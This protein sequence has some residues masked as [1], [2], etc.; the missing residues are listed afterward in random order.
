MSVAACGFIQQATD[1]WPAVSCSQ[2]L[3][4][5]L[6]LSLSLSLWRMMSLLEWVHSIYFEILN[7]LHISRSFTTCAFF[8]D[9]L[10]LFPL[11]LALSRCLSLSLDLCLSLTVFCVQTHCFVVADAHSRS[12]TRTCS[13]AFA[14]L[15][16]ATQSFATQPLATHA[17]ATPSCTDTWPQTF[18]F[19]SRFLCLSFSF[20]F[21]IFTLARI[22][23]CSFPNDYCICDR[24]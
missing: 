1:S 6:S 16:L 17:L 10:L 21:S 18:L 4:L 22:R 3:L 24:S 11:A 15:S 14:T 12:L 8:F 13:H 7:K 20:P 23:T 2:S 19:V 5:S 9:V